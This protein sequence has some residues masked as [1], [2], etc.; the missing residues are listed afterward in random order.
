MSSRTD[1]GTPAGVEPGAAKAPGG[2]S[3]RDRLANEGSE[4]G[5]DPQSDIDQLE[6]GVKPAAADK[7]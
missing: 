3:E 5:G 1:T 4:E 2:V 6:A 7:G